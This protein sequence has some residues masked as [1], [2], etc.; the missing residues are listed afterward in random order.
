[1]PD[2]LHGGGFHVLRAIFN[3]FYASLL[4]PI[5]AALRWKQIKGSD[6][7]VCSQQATGLA[8][9][10]VFEEVERQ[11]YTAFT[12]YLDSNETLK[13]EWQQQESFK[14]RASFFART[15]E[16]WCDDRLARFGECWNGLLPNWS[17]KPRKNVLCDGLLNQEP[18]KRPWLPI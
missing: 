12:I 9:M 13:A 16:S 8:L 17:W 1:M 3:L 5:Q 15:F 10:V 14:D 4:Q 11:L 7:P 2:D 18:T 6:V